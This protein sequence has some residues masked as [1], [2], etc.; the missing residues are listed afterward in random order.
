MQVKTFV[1][2]PTDTVPNSTLPLLFYQAIFPSSNAAQIET[3]FRSNKW[4]PQVP[5][6]RP[7]CFPSVLLRDIRPSLRRDSG[8]AHP[9]FSASGPLIVC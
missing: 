9:T 6:P 3:K 1:L 7:L 5:Q 4:I 8:F 2:G